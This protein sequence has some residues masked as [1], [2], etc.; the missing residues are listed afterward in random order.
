[1]NYINDKGEMRVFE[2]R[3]KTVTEDGVVWTRKS[4]EKYKSRASRLQD[5]IGVLETLRDEI[6]GYKMATDDALT[7][8][9]IKDIS[10]SVSAEPDYSEL[11]G[12]KEEMESWRDGMQGTGLENSNKYQMCE[13]AINALESA[14]STLESMSYDAPDLEDELTEGESLDDKRTETVEA[15]QNVI[16]EL[17]TAISELEGIEFPTMYS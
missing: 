7:L 14:V 5:G 11:E 16:D 15:M 3:K 13:D 2:G 17:E 12:L 4:K 10:D 9:A 1:M 6:E 8:E